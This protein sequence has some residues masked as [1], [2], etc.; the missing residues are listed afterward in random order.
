[1]W[2]AEFVR[3]LSEAGADVWWDV[4]NLRH[5]LIAAEVSKQIEACPI[6]IVI[7]TPDSMQRPWI[8]SEW[9]TAYTL[10]NRYP[11]Q[12]R[13][14]LPVVAKECNMPALLDSLGGIRGHPDLTP[15]EAAEKTISALGIVPPQRAQARRQAKPKTADAAITRAKA[16]LVQDRPAEALTIFE[17]AHALADKKRDMKL[18]A[19]SSVGKAHSLDRLK[20]SDAALAAFAEAI[21][22]L[23]DY[24]Q[25]WGGRGSLLGRLGR[26]AEALPDLD[27]AVKLKPDYIEVW[28]NR[29][30]VL[31]HLKNPKEA[32]ES[33]EQALRL[34]PDYGPALTIR[35]DALE[36]LGKLD[37]A[38]ASYDAALAAPTLASAPTT[39]PEQWQAVALSNRGNLFVK[40][41]YP[42]TAHASYQRA[43][44]L[45]P[46][47]VG[48]WIGSGHALWW[49]ARYTEALDAYDKALA[50]A[51]DASTLAS[52][53]QGKGVT[54]LK[55]DKPTEAE[56]AFR[57]ALEAKPGMGEALQGLGDAL[58]AQGNTS[59]A[60]DAYQSA[61]SSGQ[62][63]PARLAEVW[64]SIGVIHLSCSQLEKALAAFDQGI[65]AEPSVARC[66]L[67][68]SATLA[69]QG[70]SIDAE[71]VET[72]FAHRL[73]INERNR[74]ERDGRITIMQFP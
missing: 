59:G 35:A 3:L 30:T 9:S 27:R 67:N 11:D 48:A 26:D 18:L 74:M 20:R 4:A 49:M 12:Q 52:A 60:L 71:A 61:V 66:W 42:E 21:Q 41:R 6:F 65:S 55:L 50:G 73:L 56:N 45:D 57:K 68:K 46:S 7:L 16:L 39:I 34:Q 29:S 64:S 5:G 28:L 63:E 54:F 14:I 2:C 72:E 40:L 8:E 47:Y 24:A 51:T 17:L 23:P 31:R 19:A 37:A 13:I 1:M 25:A 44:A 69:L 58:R 10:R 62:L 36:D 43:V 38:L 70:K 33:A 53:W 32:V 15:A 22:N